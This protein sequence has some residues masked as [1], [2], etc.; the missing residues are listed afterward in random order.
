MDRN[1]GDPMRMNISQ[2]WAT[3]AQGSLQVEAQMEETEGEDSK[4]QGKVQEEEKRAHQQHK[5]WEKP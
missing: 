1:R 5:T 4:E 2:W 3:I